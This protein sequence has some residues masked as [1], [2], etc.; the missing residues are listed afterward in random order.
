MEILG[1]R[2]E[3]FYSMYHG[4][5]CEVMTGIPENSIHY[6]IFSP[7]FHPC[8]HIPTVTGIWGTAKQIVSFMNIS[9]T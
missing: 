2:I 1:Q 6:T 7:P 9:A 8:I 3:E 4:D 5:A